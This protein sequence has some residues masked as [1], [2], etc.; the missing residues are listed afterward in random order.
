LGYLCLKIPATFGV[1]SIFDSQQDARNIKK[2]FASGHKNVYFQREELGQHS[3]FTSNHKAQAPAEC[4]KAI[5]AKGEFKKVLLDPRVPDRTICIS[6]E[7]SQREQAELLAFLDKN[8]D[9]FAWSTADLVGVS[10][11]VIE[12]RLQVSLSARP[13]KQKLRKMS[14]EKVEA[15][16]VDVQRLLDA[17]FI[18]EVTYPQWPVN[19]VTERKK[20][21]KW[22]M[23][24]DFI[25][26]NK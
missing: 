18:R 24:I 8:S 16:K 6:M 2:G 11:D 3:T 15:V 20:N 21:G 19:V 1:I 17:S 14:E 12:H 9:V 22:R 25:D 10:R 26:L 5:E 7:A 13:K 4:K 23:C